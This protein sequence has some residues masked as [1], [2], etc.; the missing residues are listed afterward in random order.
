MAVAERQDR[1]GAGSVGDARRQRDGDQQPADR[2]ARLAARDDQPDECERQEREPLP[3]AREVR[4]QR[5]EGDVRDKQ[6]HGADAG[7]QRRRA[8]REDGERGTASPAFRAAGA[9]DTL[10]A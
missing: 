9:L 3:G 1:V 7:D 4:G 8:R 2:V 6:R 5:V 10:Q